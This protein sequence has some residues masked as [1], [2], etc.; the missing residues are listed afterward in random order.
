M[1]DIMNNNREYM[2]SVFAQRIAFIVAVY[3]LRS[4]KKAA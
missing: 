4:A 2:S 1:H 3:W